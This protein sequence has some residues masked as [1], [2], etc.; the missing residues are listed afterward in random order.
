MIPLIKE[1]ENQVVGW[2]SS[3]LTK[4]AD[5]VR[6]HN[7][8]PLVA[9]EEFR[10]MGYELECFLRTLFPHVHRALMRGSIVTSFTH[11]N[12]EFSLDA[13]SLVKSLLGKD[14]LSANA[15]ASWR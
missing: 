5:L 6:K 1:L 7:G 9:T 14:P 4:A 10:V 15:K 11:K 12:G 8:D 2:A 13:R 3:R